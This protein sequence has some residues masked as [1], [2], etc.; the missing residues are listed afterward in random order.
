MLSVDHALDLKA[1]TGKVLG[2]S[3][4]QTITQ[5]D[6]DGFAALTGD[7]HWIHVDV[8]RA[9]QEMPQGRTIVHGLLMLGMAPAL[10][11]Q[12]YTIHNRGRGLNYGY[13]RVRFVS[14]VMVDSR[15]RLKQS[16]ADATEHKIGT[17]LEF[18]IEIEVEGADKPALV[19]RHLLLIEDK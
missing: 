11:R 19:A 17:K 2:Y 10:Q 12:V 14:P 15:V 9:K 13:D 18:D 5:K 1:H 3:E 4:W 16:L 8:A 6:I 7:D